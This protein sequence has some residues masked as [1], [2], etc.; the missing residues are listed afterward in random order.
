M[1]HSFDIIV[2]GAGLSG[3]TIAEHAAREG[4]KVL[5]VEKRDHI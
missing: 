1:N 5:V 3:A 4:A 2:V